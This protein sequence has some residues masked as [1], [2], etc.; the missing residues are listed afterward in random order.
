ME[1][2]EKGTIKLKAD[3]PQDMVTIRFLG[4]ING[5]DANMR[6]YVPK[7]HFKSSNFKSMPCP[8]CDL[9]VKISD[10]TFSGSTSMG[11]KKDG[12]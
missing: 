7:A 4:N 8:V 2:T 9:K 11:C 3:D 1:D 10:I 12:K 5:V 6:R